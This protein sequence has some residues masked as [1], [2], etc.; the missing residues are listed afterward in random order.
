[1]NMRSSII[2]VTL[3]FCVLSF[4]YAQSPCNPHPLFNSLPQH[5]LS[6]CEEKEFDKIQI[7]YTDK[8]G[9]WV[10]Y[11]KSGYLLK[12]YYTFEGDWEKRPSNAMIFQNYIKAVT[13]KGGT[14]INESKSAV[15]LTLK[16]AGD[17]WWIKVQSDQSGTYAVTCVK[18]ESMQQYIVLSAEDIAKEI[19]AN[20]KAT[21]YGIYFDT[22]KSEI[23]PES[24]E[25]IEQMAKYLQKNTQVNVY[26]VGH[27]D[28]T[29]SFEHNQQLSQKRAESVVNNLINNYQI[30]ASRLKG[31]G[32]SSLSPVSTNTTEEGKSK[33]RRVEMVL[34]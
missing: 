30:S 34:R 11:E 19:K 18:E 26:I 21:F 14:V 27:T 17:A 22:D 10:Q 8:D 25:T 16:L 1:M 15:L 4:G 5:I 33:N 6:D 9:T 7:D 12:T 20:G 24:K 31:F 23:K 29:G 32:V 2:S 28:N 3:L 13:S